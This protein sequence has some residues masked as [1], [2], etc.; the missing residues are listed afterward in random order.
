APWPMNLPDQYLRKMMRGIVAFEIPIDRLEG[1]FKLSQNR[2]A[3]DQ[4]RVIEALDTGGG[5]V[6]QQVAAMM[7]AV[8]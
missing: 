7:R 3:I 2:P 5:P 4:Q 8:L 6:E 1:K